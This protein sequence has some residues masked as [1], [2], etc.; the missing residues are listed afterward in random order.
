MRRKLLLFSFF[1]MCLSAALAGQ[2]SLPRAAV[3]EFNVKGDVAVKDAG[4]T[5]AEWLSAALQ[6]TGKYQVLERILLDKVL[7]EQ[8]IA[9]SGM[10]DQATS[11]KIGSFSGAQ[12][13]VSGSIIEWNHAYTLTARIINLTTGAVL[14]SAPFRTT[15][16]GQISARMDDIAGVLVGTVPIE[17][18]DKASK[19][20]AF[21]MAGGAAPNAAISVVRATPKQGKIRVILDRGSQDRVASGAVFGIFVPVFGTSEVSGKEVRQG[22]KRVGAVMVDYVEP[23]FAAGDFQPEIAVETTPKVLMSDAV[24]L[25]STAGFSMDL[26]VLNL[27]FGFVTSIGTPGGMFNAL[28]GI[29]FAVP[30]IGFY[31]NGLMLGAGWELPIVGNYLSQSRVGLG[32]MALGGMNMSAQQSSLIGEDPWLVYGGA[33][34]ANLALGWFSLRLGACCTV[35]SVFSQTP[36]A[37]GGTLTASRLSVS[38]FVFLGVNFMYIDPNPTN[39]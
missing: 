38:P 15:D 27:G 2:N 14:A 19:S 12:V 34:Y 20:G 21:G 6:R 22:M 24:A 4:S 33:A 25:P 39:Y 3:V 28:F 18:L 10:I 17:V 23:N 31:E 1:I 29:D 26:G 13:V 7:A 37:V 32:L 8:D 36:D 5:I 35:E 30:T 16:L 9:L 11:A